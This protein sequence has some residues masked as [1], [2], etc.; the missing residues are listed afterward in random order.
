MVKATASV[1]LSAD[2]MKKLR[3]AEEKALEM[4]EQAV[5]DD[6]VAQAVVPKRTGTL[7]KSGFIREAREGVWQVVFSTPYARRLYWHPE[8]HFRTDKNPNAQGKW[9]HSYIYGDNRD[10]VI[11]TYKEFLRQ[12]ARGLIR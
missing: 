11:D 2:K 10:W 9:M 8:Y 12:Y 3:E 6:A 4:T 1:T 7:E 5:L